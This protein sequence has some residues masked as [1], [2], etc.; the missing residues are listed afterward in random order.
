M[1]QSNERSFQLVEVF[2][3]KLVGGVLHPQGIERIAQ[4]PQA[5]AQRMRKQASHRATVNLHIQQ[6]EE[7]VEQSDVVG[8]RIHKRLFFRV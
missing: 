5:V 4:P 8:L 6:A 1:G 3:R 7:A 2:R